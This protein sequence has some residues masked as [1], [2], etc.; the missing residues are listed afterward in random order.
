MRLPGRRLWRW[1]H[2]RQSV[3]AHLAF[4]VLLACVALA[5]AAAAAGDPEAGA[6]AFVVCSAC[7]A[8]SPDGAALIGPNLHGVVGRQVGSVPGFDYSPELK[9]VGGAWTPERIDRFLADPNGFAPGT[10]MGL[11]GIADPAERANLVAYLGSLAAGAP[12]VAAAP[13]PDFGDD[14]P[15]GPG[16]AETGVLCNSCHS[17]AIVKQQQLSRETWDKLLVW[18][19]DEQGMAEQAPER[20]ELILDYLATHFGAP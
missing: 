19:V 1:R 5:S 9:A 17:L 4:A 3:S 7:H 18:M 15:A 20:R 11:V 14:W 16:Q 8:V 2:D 6:K 12:A 10:R 13:L